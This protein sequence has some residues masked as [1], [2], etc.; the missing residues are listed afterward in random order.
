MVT[1]T[2]VSATPAVDFTAFLTPR[3]DLNLSAPDKA[4]DEFGS[5]LGCVYVLHQ[6]VFMSR[7][8]ADSS[9]MCC[10]IEGCDQAQDDISSLWRS[11]TQDIWTFEV[12]VPGH[13]S[14]L[15]ERV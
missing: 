10:P 1:N 3:L 9:G 13:S 5:A 8:S 12:C 4:G 15:R 6:Y 11:L 7:T 14:V 2:D